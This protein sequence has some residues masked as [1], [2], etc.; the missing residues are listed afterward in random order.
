MDSTY[1]KMFYHHG[2]LIGGIDESGVSDIAGPLV[3]AC[4]VLPKID[5]Q[6]DDLRIFEINDSK[7][8]PERYR[9]YH[10]EVIW[11]VALGIG[12]GEV[13]PYEIDYLGKHAATRLAM[14][15]AIAACRK[16]TASKSYMKP[17]Y[18][19]IDGQMTIGTSIKH[20]LIKHGDTKSLC[21]AAASLV[22]KVYRD[23]IMVKY[24]ELYPHYAFNRSKGYPCDKHLAGLDNYGIQVGV[25]RIRSWPIS[26]DPRVR[27]VGSAWRKRRALWRKKTEELF[28]K[29]LGDI[30]TPRDIEKKSYDASKDLK[31]SEEMSE[32]SSLP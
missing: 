13:Q 11:Q 8:V 22:A 20:S 29:N 14:L 28:G 16:T 27:E 17:D 3:A 31:N 24:H 6:K 32:K 10:A 30:W 26:P 23:D 2:E 5:V 25:H 4:V 19:L 15:R 21:I 12:I 18:L 9:K 1:D 7:L